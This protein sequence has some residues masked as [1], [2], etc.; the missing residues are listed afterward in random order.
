MSAN[1]E[2]AARL[3]Q[4]RAALK[5]NQQEMADLLAI[6]FQR[7]NNIE[8]G[9]GLSYEVAALIC[10]RIPG[11]TLDWL[12]F[13]KES[14]LTVDLAGRLSEALISTTTPSVP[15]KRRRSSRN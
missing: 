1:D 11:M 3:K 9:S 10:Q 14:G 12:Y 5:H 13:G 7:Y 6:S 8:R 4:L 2:E 15:P